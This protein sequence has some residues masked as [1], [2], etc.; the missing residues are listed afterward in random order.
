MSTVLSTEA[1]LPAREHKLRALRRMKRVALGL[2]GLAAGV[3]VATLFLPPSLGM[4]GLRAVAEAAM[5]GALA[6]WFAVVALFRRPLGLPIPHT[7]VIP[8]NKDR[9]ADN[10]ARFVQ[11]K[12]L[13]PDALIAQMRR[14]DPAAYLAQWL[15]QPANVRCIGGHV[16]RVA[17]TWLQ[18]VDDK[19]MQGFFG[20]A[21]R[22]VINKI[23]LSPALGSMLD[24]LTRDGRHQQ[25]LDALIGYALREL[26]KPSVRGEIARRVVQWLKEEHKWKQLLIPTEWLT[27]QVVDAAGSVIDRLLTDISQRPEHEIRAIFDG[28][29]DKLVAQLRQNEAFLRKGDELK[30][31]IL[32]NAAMA[33]YARDLWAQLRGWLT[34]DLERPADASRVLQH[35]E[36]IGAWLADELARDE[37]LRRSLNDYLEALAQLLAP[38]LGDFLTGH[39]RDTV[40]KWDAGDMS[41]QIELQI[42]ADLQFIRINGTLVG[43]AIGLLLFVIAHAAQI[44]TALGGG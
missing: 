20:D 36:R 44:W 11:E 14:I 30:E 21:L 35:T 9:I 25:L 43:G 32:H 3:F 1:P 27:T 40:R 2:F 34:D 8:S 41:E 15:A 39:I 29:V 26:Q 17:R 38:Q 18:F 31:Y 28:Q 19:P 33:G 10:L 12:F 4:I 23:D 7:A 13:D 6:D 5:V 16:G 24:V 22:T 37:A 42:G